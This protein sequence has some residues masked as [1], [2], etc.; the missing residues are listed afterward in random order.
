MKNIQFKG[1]AISSLLGG[2]IVE[3]A[4]LCV[5][6]NSVYGQL[7]C[8][9]SGLNKCEHSVLKLEG[10]CG[11]SPLGG[12]WRRWSLAAW[13]PSRTPLFVGR[14]KLATPQSRPKALIKRQQRHFP[15][16]T[17]KSKHKF[18][19]PKSKHMYLLFQSPNTC[20]YFVCNLASLTITYYCTCCT[21]LLNLLRVGLVSYLFP[22]VR[23]HLLARLCF[24]T[25]RSSTSWG[26]FKIDAFKLSQHHLC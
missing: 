15:D 14:T 16:L 5:N 21:L 25:I 9:P 23:W 20:V 11:C 19:T 7:D 10:N 3:P 17:P 26:P 1:S 24:A 4:L 8:P 6:G 22:C 18:Q 2:E 12:D 13:P